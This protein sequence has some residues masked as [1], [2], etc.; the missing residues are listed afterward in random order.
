MSNWL[1]DPLKIVEEKKP[2][3]QLYTAYFDDLKGASRLVYFLSDWGTIHFLIH[4][5]N[6]LRD[7][8][9]IHPILDLIFS[10]YR[11]YGFSLCSSPPFPSPIQPLMP[12]LPSPPAIWTCS[13]STPGFGAA[14]SERYACSLCTPY[15]HYG[16]WKCTRSK[17][18]NETQERDSINRKITVPFTLWTM[19]PRP[20]SAFHSALARGLS[21]FC[22]SCIFRN[23]FWWP[24]FS[25]LDV[26]SLKNRTVAAYICLKFPG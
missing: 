5:P 15:E 7:T 2:F 19:S 9:F 21:T 22:A 14:L 1:K 6:H 26:K 3:F 23:I 17:A 8:I 11:I 18:P 4:S 12:L 16:L 10:S 13:G 25:V 20:R 24:P